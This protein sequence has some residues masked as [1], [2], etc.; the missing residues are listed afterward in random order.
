MEPYQRILLT[1]CYRAYMNNEMVNPTRNTFQNMFIYI[2][3]LRDHS[4]TAD[5]IH[6]FYK[7][8]WLLPAP[9]VSRFNIHE[10]CNIFTTANNVKHCF[11]R[12]NYI[13]LCKPAEDI[14]FRRCSNIKA[15]QNVIHCIQ[16]QCTSERNLQ[17]QQH[18]TGHV[19]SCVWELWHRNQEHYPADQL[20]EFWTPDEPYLLQYMWTSLVV[21]FVTI[22][23]CIAT[24]INICNIKYNI[25][26]PAHLITYSIS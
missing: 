24:Q 1:L 14:K 19:L 23:L 10:I 25:Y 7:H 22:T 4:D 18:C 12:K 15:L 8:A 11:T 21:H 3:M 26:P 6:V 16:M 9:L 5:K 17:S 20:S 13:N 2:D